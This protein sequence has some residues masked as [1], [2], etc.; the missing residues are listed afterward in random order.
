MEPIVPELKKA[1][2]LNA[3]HFDDPDTPHID[4]PGASANNVIEGVEVMKIRDQVVPILVRHGIVVHAVP[5]Q[6]NLAKSIAWAN[7]RAPE[8]NDALAV[9]IHLNYLSTTSARG[10]ESFYGETDTSKA[11]A[12]AITKAVSHEMGIP[13]RGAKPD[14]QTAVGEL[15]WI[16]KTTMWASLIEVCF[17]TNPEDMAVLH[18]ADGY[19]RAAIGIA[20][21]ILAVF[22]MEYQEPST[23]TVPD[24]NL[25]VC[26]ADGKRLYKLTKV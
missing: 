16:R 26:D 1:V 22:G 18:G 9:D 5:D 19:E 7:Q 20:K 21:G 17:L 25:Y 3:G 14:T 15:G 10:S 4:D 8:L 12:S 13:D 11:I 2:I 23:P 24:G 6:L